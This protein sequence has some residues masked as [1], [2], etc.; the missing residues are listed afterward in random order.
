MRQLKHHEKKLLRKVDFV[1]WKHERNLQEVKVL[2]RYMIQNRDDY[3]KCV[4]EG[5]AR[6]NGV[7][8]GVVRNNVGWVDEDG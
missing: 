1:Q 3:V 6:L 8:R 4:R 7:G 2:R 5:M